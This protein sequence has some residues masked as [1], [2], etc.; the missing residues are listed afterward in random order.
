MSRFLALT[1]GLLLVP[2]AAY[3][4]AAPPPDAGTSDPKAVAL[5]S[6]MSKTY[7]GLKSYSATETATGPENMGLPYTMT[8]T[9]ARPGS[10]NMTV[11]HG[12]SSRPVTIHIVSDGA[13]YFAASSQS[14]LRYLKTTPPTK[15]SALEEAMSRSDIKIPM[16][17]ILLE[18]GQ[19]WDKGMKDQKTT[20]YRLGTPGTRDGVAVDTVLMEA[21][22]PDYHSRATLEI[23][24]ADHLLRRM[25]GTDENKGL[26]P[27]TTVTTFTDVRADPVLSASAFAFVPP[28]GATAATPASDTKGDPEAVALMTQ[29]YA[30]YNALHSF[31]CAATVDAALPVHDGK[32]KTTIINQHSTATYALIKPNQIAFTRTTPS[33]SASAICDGHTLYAQTSEGGSGPEEWQARPR[34]LKKAA[35]DGT[36]WNDKLELAR[37]GGLPQYGVSDTRDWMPEVALGADFMP[38]DGG[39]GWQVGAPAALNGEPMDVVT[40]AQSTV[41]QGGIP[42]DSNQ[43]TLTLWISPKDHLLRQIRQVWARADGTAIT[44]ETYAEV[45]ANPTL[46]AAT[47]AWTPPANG[48]AVD[49]PEALTPPRPAFGP[50]LHVGNAPPAAV[51]GVSDVTGKPVTPA[52][53][54]GKFLVLDFWATWCGPCREQIPSTVAAYEKNHARGLEIVGYA[55]EQAKAKDKMPAF[56]RAHDMTWREVWDKDGVAANAVAASGIPFAI[57]VGRDGKIAALGNPGEDGL[58]LP[59]A[60][61][62]A[63]A[64]P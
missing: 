52:D 36:G 41:F 37:F 9:Y 34:Y 35:P 6:Q 48:V 46:P 11:V 45:K 49:T 32:G 17:M 8:L 38:A 33:G 64:K 63:L 58:D 26:P 23:G 50:A 31:S 47:F 10:V 1:A 40:S 25:A 12:P 4:Q 27:M 13:N 61:E 24:H 20:T 14:P 62:A 56:A 43:G 28:P 54:K 59:A 19:E 22:T 5:M 15:T 30:A 51:F 42:D 57:V 44:T 55:L 16:Q 2:V 21:T 18:H 3:A 7:A 29:M 39:Y 53:Y 60:V